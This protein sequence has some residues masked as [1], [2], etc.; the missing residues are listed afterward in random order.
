MSE[1]VW[2]QLGLWSVGHWVLNGGEQ[3]WLS[4]REAEHKEDFLPQEEQEQ[5]EVRSRKEW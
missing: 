5:R 3:W 1:G 4:W 2:Q